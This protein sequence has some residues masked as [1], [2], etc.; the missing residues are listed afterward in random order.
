MNLPATVTIIEVGLRDG[1]QNEQIIPT[2]EQKI[3]IIHGL[4]RAGIREFQVTSFV[5]PKQVPQMAD[6]DQLFK[7]LP[8]LP[9]IT[10]SG[11]VLNMKGLERAYQAGVQ[12]VDIGMSV[13]NTHSLKNTGKSVSDKQ[14]EILEMIR[15]AKSWGMKVRAGLQ[16]VFG[17]VY[18]GQIA[19]APIMKMVEAY[20]NV[21]VDELSLADSTGMGNPLSIEAILNAVQ[22]TTADLPLVL[23][24]H[25]T[26]GLGIANMVVALQMGITRF[27]SA[28][29]GLGGCPFIDGA[30]GNIATEDVVYTLNA[31]NIETGIDLQTLSSF[32]RQLE[33]SLHLTFAS[34]VYQLV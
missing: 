23:H 11:L 25:D 26:Y 19:Q 10:Y 20:L 30:K 22:N 21:G 6:A 9:N 4:V 16:C 32:T 24:L 18:E 15:V 34:R 5:H 14:P 31:M 33:K 8:L 7:Q 17:C 2:V 27:D 29:G 3:D 13:S 28:F 12:K 1:L